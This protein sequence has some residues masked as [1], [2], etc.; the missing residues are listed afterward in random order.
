LFILVLGICAIPFR[1]RIRAPVA[2]IARI[3]RGEKSVA[4]RLREFGDTVHGRLAARFREI[5]VH[6]P[7]EK[8]V[9][10]GLKQERLLEVW[11]SDGRTG[12]QHLKT[13]PILGASGTLGPK[14]SEGDGQ[15][16]E[17]LYKI[18]SLNPN[19]LYHLALQIDYPNG[20]DKEQGRHD[21]RANLGSDIMIHGSSLSVGCVA[22]GDEAAE[23]LFVLAAEVGVENVELILSPVD[24][25]VRELPT[26]LPQSPSWTSELYVE[27]R[28]ALAR[29]KRQ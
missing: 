2:G 27:I 3:L 7:P 19:S 16:P 1:A 11:V 8:M 21:G 29:L 24:F 28:K 4:D 5:D 20:F 13:Y 9:I 25:R 22:I 10:V 23:D 12:L 17:G 14:L 6:Y 26:N 18:D 15:V